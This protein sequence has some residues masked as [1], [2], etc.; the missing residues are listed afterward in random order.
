MRKLKTLTVNGQTYVIE[1][2]DS[3]AYLA[4][5][6]SSNGKTC[7]HTAG[8]IYSHMQQGGIVVATCLGEYLPMAACSDIEAIFANTLAGSSGA[9]TVE[10]RVDAAGNVIR[11]TAM[12]GGG[13]VVDKTLTIAG[14][15]AD[16][17]TV[18]DQLG[19]IEAAL[20]HIIQ[21]QNAL[22]GGEA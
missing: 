20:D 11:K 14:A 6:I 10:F 17:K 16:A 22:I 3:A 13:A 18:G 7:S 15:A 8:Q 4:V 21:M 5:E 12:G 2:G 9:E 19:D 1:D